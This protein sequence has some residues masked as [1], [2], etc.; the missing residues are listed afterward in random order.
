MGFSKSVSKSIWIPGVRWLMM[1]VVSFAAT[2]PAQATQ[3]S[4]E[5]LICQS[6]FNRPVSDR[7]VTVR[8]KARLQSADSSEE[9]LCIT[10]EFGETSL[11]F[12]PKCPGS[13]D[14]NDVA[15]QAGKAK[16]KIDEK[17]VVPDNSSAPNTSRQLPHPTFDQAKAISDV[18]M[19]VALK[20]P[21][22]GKSVKNV[23]VPPSLYLD[24]VMELQ[25]RHASVMPPTEVP[26][27]SARVKFQLQSG[28]NG[29]KQYVFLR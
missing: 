25:N 29:I 11:V 9:G 4:C 13:F 1:V 22:S 8:A 19:T 24:V 3:T 2:A 7:S 14:L 27:S 10:D 26:P 23:S 15:S 17:S 5:P 21:K 6:A 16:S 28:T 18:I 20:K 12:L